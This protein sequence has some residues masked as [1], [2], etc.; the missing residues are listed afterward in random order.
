[1]LFTLYQ[2]VQKWQGIWNKERTVIMELPC[3]WYK[4]LFE[5]ENQSE[6]PEAGCV[7]TVYYG[8][9]FLYTMGVLWILVMKSIRGTWITDR[10]RN[11]LNAEI[12]Y[13][14]KGRN[15]W[16]TRGKKNTSKSNILELNPMQNTHIHCYVH[17]PYKHFKWWGMLLW[18]G[19]LNLLLISF[20]R[21]VH[22]WRMPHH[23]CNVKL[24][25][26]RWRWPK[27]MVQIFPYWSSAPL[28]HALVH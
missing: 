6:I 1:M 24:S 7:Q 22:A 12:I 18:K 21:P 4:W 15:V 9:H 28:M 13:M 16:G 3:D 23:P 26:W 25:W 2:I 27:C 14:D 20:W 10:W 8:N 19:L 5:K 17:N 11:I